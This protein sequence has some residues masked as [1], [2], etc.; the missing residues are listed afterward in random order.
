MYL[1]CEL[2]VRGGV[3]LL[4][5]DRKVLFRSITYEYTTNHFGVGATYMEL[6]N[7]TFCH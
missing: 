7:R 6:H 3:V 4:D 5:G 2:F 1:I